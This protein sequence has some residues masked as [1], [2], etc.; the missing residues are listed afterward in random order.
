MYIIHSSL[1]EQIGEE[2]LFDYTTPVVIAVAVAALLLC[3][4]KQTSILIYIDV[5]MKN[6]E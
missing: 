3:S 6:D 4:D 2:D 1:W 5:M